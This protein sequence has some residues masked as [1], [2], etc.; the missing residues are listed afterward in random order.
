[1]C[2]HSD[3]FLGSAVA[4]GE[5]AT[6]IKRGSRSMG[7]AVS[8]D[9]AYLA[10]RGL[11]TLHA[12]LARH[13]DAA[14]E[15]AAWLQGQPMV[16]EVLCPQLPGTRGHEIFRR[17]FSAGNGLVTIVLNGPEIAEHAFFNALRLFGLGFPGAAS[18]ALPSRATARS[19]SALSRRKPAIRR[20][21]STWGWN[22]PQT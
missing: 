2:G 21:A 7:W 9:D 5:A 4:N 3:V 6:L 20:S 17:H 1:V 11:R 12:R 18:R 16:R 19:A 22:T 15:V 10:L 13:G 8:S 14:L